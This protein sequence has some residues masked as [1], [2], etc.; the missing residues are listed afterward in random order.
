M[1]LSLSAR[2]VVNVEALNMVESVGNVTRHRRASVIIET[3]EGYRKVEVPAVS[4]ETIAHGYQE[5]L[6]KVANVIYDG[7][8]PICKWCSRGEFF[9]EMDKAHTIE[10]A[11]KITGERE[12]Y[13]H[14]FEKIVIAKCLVEDI[15][16]FLKAERPPVR[17][18][19][20]FQ[21]GYM[22]P[23]KDAIK[24]SSLESQFHARHAPSEPVKAEQERAAQMIYYVEVGSAVYGLTFNL[25]IDGIGYTSL[26]KKEPAVDEEER[27]R[28]IK[29]ALSALLDLLSGYGFGAKRTRFLP[30]SEIRSFA[31]AISHPMPFT[32]LPPSTIGFINESIEKKRKFIEAYSTVGVD[33]KVRMF[34][35]SKE[36]KE[37][38]K[39]KDV[40]VVSSLEE[41]LRKVMEY[42]LK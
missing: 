37:I 1:F 19:S 12:E 11:K 8:P 5:A 26:V 10:E 3:P 38:A 39:D 24:V 9:K 21:V 6:V 7:R 16:G 25:D 33:E 36:V 20:R 2:L 22:V 32:V 30:I 40:E 31:L 23:V 17:R 13:A 15:G 28:R 42:V 41:A 35:F 18:T 34:V 27:K 4:G 14:A 29:V